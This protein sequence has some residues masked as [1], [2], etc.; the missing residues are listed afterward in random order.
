MVP[1]YVEELVE[2]ER[3]KEKRED[4]LDASLREVFRSFRPSLVKACGGLRSGRLNG[5]PNCSWES[6]FKQY[7]LTFP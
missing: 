6:S 4:A 2:N 3:F 7:I 5:L 1:P